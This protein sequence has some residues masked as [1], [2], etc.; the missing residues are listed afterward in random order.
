MH[1]TGNQFGT[2]PSCVRQEPAA[3]PLNFLTLCRMFPRSET[4]RERESVCR[5]ESSR[6]IQQLTGQVSSHDNQYQCGQPLL[7][8]GIMAPIPIASP[9]QRT[10]AH[11]A[12]R[13]AE[14]SGRRSRHKQSRQRRKAPCSREERSQREHV[15]GRNRPETGAR[16]TGRLPDKNN[17]EQ[18]AADDDGYGLK[19]WG[20]PC[21]A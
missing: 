19:H 8:L 12:R 2:L 9:K 13:G 10:R 4:Q 18:V 15:R 5:P 6:P 17:R 1:G 11:A 16:A 7:Q 3:D 21:R 20:H 14:Q